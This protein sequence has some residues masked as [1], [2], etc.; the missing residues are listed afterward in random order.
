MDVRF[1]EESDLARIMDL[2]NRAFRVEGFFIDGD[3]LNDDRLRGYFDHG[4]FLLAEENGTLAG[5][6]YVELHS[7]YAYLGLL[8]V[9]PSFQ[10]IGLGRRLA[11][12]AEEFAREMGTHRM[13]LTV[14][15]L[16]TELPPLY[17]KLGYTIVGTEPIRKE[18]ESR[19]TQPCH[20][21]RMSKTLG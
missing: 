16:R 6:V 9:E 17:E 18:M 5:C 21:I 19:V 8:S 15:N 11:T 2:V 13:D 14:V 7:D 20:F 10:R 3:R 12:A 1:A 4:R